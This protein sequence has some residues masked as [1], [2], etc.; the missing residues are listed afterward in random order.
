MQ[1]VLRKLRE[2][3]P[4]RPCCSEPNQLL[5]NA[6]TGICKADHTEVHDYASADT[7]TVLHR[8]HAVAASKCHLP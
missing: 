1:K 8:Q 6:L 2:A 4:S 7:K 5:Y 3:V